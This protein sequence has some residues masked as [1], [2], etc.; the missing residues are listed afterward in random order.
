MIAQSGKEER[1][2]ET[3]GSEKQFE[4][5]ERRYGVECQGARAEFPGAAKPETRIER[6]NLASSALGKGFS[7]K[8][9][10]IY[11]LKGPKKGIYTV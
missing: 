6:A 2:R 9:I 8:N 3:S 4:G 11:G 5:I 7:G 1:N 10:Y